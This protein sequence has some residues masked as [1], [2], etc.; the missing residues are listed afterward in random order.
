[1]FTDIKDY[2]KKPLNERQ[3][4]IDETAECI[5]I[6]GDSRTCRGLLAHMLYTTMDFKHAFICHYCG[7]S[8]CSNPKHL[9]WGTPFENNEDKKRHGTWTDIQESCIK[10]YGEKWATIQKE[11]CRKIGKLNGGKNK[12]SDKVLKQRLCD[13]ESDRTRGRYTRISKKWGVSHTRVRAFEK[14]HKS[15]LNY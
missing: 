1:M 10:K 8:K 2:L 4:H 7:N 12:V 9:Y 14:Q 5:E 11:N 3:E 15:E 6:G 13:L